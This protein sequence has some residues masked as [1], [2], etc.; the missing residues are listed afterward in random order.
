MGNLLLAFPSVAFGV[1]HG[2][3]GVGTEDVPSAGPG[4][5]AA[6]Q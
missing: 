1:S 6:A 4:E 3:G 5:T 2:V